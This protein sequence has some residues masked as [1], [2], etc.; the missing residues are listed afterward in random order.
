MEK[1]MRVDSVQDV[2]DCIHQACVQTKSSNIFL[3]SF[4]SIRVHWRL[5][6]YTCVR[7]Q[8]Y[9]LIH[10]EIAENQTWIPG[11]QLY[12]CCM[13]L[14]NVKNMPMATKPSVHLLFCRER[15]ICV[16]VP[17]RP[18]S[19]THWHVF[20]ELPRNKYSTTDVPQQLQEQ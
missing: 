3:K 15:F 2:F 20:T 1:H 12:L 7:K 4:H 10:K 5:T 16:D 11:Q 6:T 8:Y 13:R 14:A 19:Q 18:I 17:E 9:Y